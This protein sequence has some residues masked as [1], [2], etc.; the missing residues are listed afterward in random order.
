MMSTMMIQVMPVINEKKTPSV[1]KKNH[2]SSSIR[3]VICKE[4]EEKG[5][6]LG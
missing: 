5:R 6:K 1:S 4:M 2:S 3:Q